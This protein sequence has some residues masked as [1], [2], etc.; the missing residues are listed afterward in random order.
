MS[1][2]AHV[3][4]IDGAL[5]GTMLIK[6]NAYVGTEELDVHLFDTTCQD[7]SSHLYISPEKIFKLNP[8]LPH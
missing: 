8:L 6:Y 5:T 3:N 7:V 4:R 1:E 2:N